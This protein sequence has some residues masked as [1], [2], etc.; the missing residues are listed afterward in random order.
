MRSG[1]I[2]TDPDPKPAAAPCA[3]P[4]QRADRGAPC[5]ARTATALA[6]T[7][8]A[9]GCGGA[10]PASGDA[11]DRA[12]LRIVAVTHGQSSDPFWSVVS[13]GLHDAGRDLGVRVEYQAPNTFDMVR[14]SQ[15]VEAAV[16]SR[17]AGLVVSVP[18]ASALAGSI[19][20][21]VAAGVPVVS[22]N[23]G[24]GAWMELGLL[25]HIGQ[26][27]YEAAFAGGARLAG[28]G[29]RRALCVNHE[30]G[31]LALDARCQGLADALRAAG[32][33]TTV[34]AIAI[35]DP[36]DARQR[37]AGA[38]AADASIDGVLTLGP[39]GAAATLAALRETGRAGR[40][41]FGTFDLGPDVLRAVASGD[42]LFAI[43]QQPYLQGY[44]A[45]TML[46]K[47]LETGAIAG[48]GQVVRTGPGFV[49][50]E[51]ADDVIR[52]TERGLR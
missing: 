31:N 11:A 37:V 6:T 23:S 34:L 39:T 5:G 51:T 27:E 36:D 22:I 49:T 3:R 13:N 26:T 12:G 28:A 20:A 29:V 21:A 43:D 8:L 48:G 47:Y 10:A 14:M 45:V 30:V 44:M 50:R 52:F 42:I 33:T 15:L 9:V 18:D 41:P 38:L 2:L 1:R 46:V 25:A 19:R 17:P 7:L 32:G 16:A 4:R 40:I 35:A 24:D